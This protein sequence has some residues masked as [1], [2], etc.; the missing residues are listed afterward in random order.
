MQSS[1]DLCVTVQLYTQVCACCWLGRLVY[2]WRQK[3][4]KTRQQDNLAELEASLAPAEAEVGAMAKADQKGGARYTVYTCS[5]NEYCI[6]EAELHSNRTFC[7]MMGRCP[8][9]YLRAF[10]S[11]LFL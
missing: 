4:N 10:R 5:V 1:T 6:P 9:E 3:Q 7:T 2:G 8:Y 11:N